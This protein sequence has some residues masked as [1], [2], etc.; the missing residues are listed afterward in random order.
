MTTTTL[1]TIVL[2]F[3][4]ALFS[5]FLFIAVSLETVPKCSLKLKHTMQILTI[6]CMLVLITESLAILFRGVPTTEAYWIVRI[7]NFLTFL[8]QYGLGM[9]YLWYLVLSIRQKCPDFHFLNVKFYYALVA[10]FISILLL[11][12]PFGFLYTFDANN[13]YQRRSGFW[14]T[15]LISF[16]ILL[17]ILGVFIKGY[18]YLTKLQIISSII[19]FGATIPCMTIQFMIY[20]LS[21]IN[22]SFAFSIVIMFF[23]HQISILDQIYKQRQELTAMKYRLIDSQIHP[24]FLFN[25]LAIISSLTKRDPDEAVEAISDLSAFIRDLLNAKDT[26]GICSILEDLDIAKHYLSMEKRRFGDQLQI[27]IDDKELINDD[28]QFDV[29][30]FTIQPLVE[31]AVSHGIRKKLGTGHLWIRF[32]CENSFN[33]IMI[34]DDGAGF[35]PTVLPNDGRSHIG[36]HNVKKRLE[37]LC[38]GIMEV[39]SA[40]GKGTRIILKIP[41]DQ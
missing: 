41:Q 12:I 32:A 19:Y 17:A 10:S 34:E 33:T 1:I 24:H 40:P 13:T 31:N 2:E 14:I 30:C 28:I 37:M 18:R 22:V 36:M 35:D 16:M 21:L 9:L 3:W 29:P 23:A 11:N 27:H 38:S 26:H 8:L 4:G 20:G 39:H 15:L 6:D 25:S 5:F 7:T